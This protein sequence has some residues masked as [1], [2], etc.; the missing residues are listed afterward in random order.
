MT[1]LRLIARWLGTIFVLTIG[2]SLLVELCH[3]ISRHT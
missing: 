2:V 1:E 3:W